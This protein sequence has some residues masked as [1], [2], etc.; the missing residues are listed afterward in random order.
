MVR[1]GENRKDM[2][3]EKG[4][5]SQIDRQTES[6]G[7]ERDRPT[8]KQTDRNSSAQAQVRLPL[9]VKGQGQSTDVGQATPMRSDRLMGDISAT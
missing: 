1:E 6:Q 7:E 9:V 3:S 4:R 5:E 2:E 8:G